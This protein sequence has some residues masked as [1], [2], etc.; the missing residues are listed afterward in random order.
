MLSIGEERHKTPLISHSPPSTSAWEDPGSQGRSDL[1][2]E[3]CSRSQLRTDA[4]I[5]LDLRSSSEARRRAAAH[6]RVMERTLQCRISFHPATLR[7]MRG[8]G[9]ESG[10]PLGSARKRMYEK[11]TLKFASRQSNAW[12]C[13]LHWW[14]LCPQ[15]Q[16]TIGQLESLQVETLMQFSQ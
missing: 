4:R 5:P 11:L 13:S 16:G 3:H 9:S 14:S 10:S 1:M 12:S 2:Y 7:V 6:G 8:A 15:S